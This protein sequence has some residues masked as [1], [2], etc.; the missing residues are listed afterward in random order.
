MKKEKKPI[1]NKIDI[2]EKTNEAVIVRATE[3]DLK[4]I[5]NEEVCEKDQIEAF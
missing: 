1:V 3:K 2:D 4:E 5:S